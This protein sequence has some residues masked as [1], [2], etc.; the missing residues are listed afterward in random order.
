[1]KPVHVALDGSGL[2]VYNRATKAPLWWGMCGMI[3]IE[4]VVFASF[5]ASYLYLKGS[6]PEL[7]PPMRDG[8]PGLLLPTL[9]TFVLIASSL[10]MHWGDKGIRRGDNR[11]LR[12]GMVGALA[13]ALLFLVLKYVEYS[14]VPYRWDSHVYGSIVWTIIGFHTAHVIAV[15]LKGFIV[16][17]LAF[18]DY[19]DERR[20]LGV[21][22]NGLYWHFVVVIWIPLYITL[23]L[24]PR[25]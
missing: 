22:V 18:R 7:F 11:Q 16:A 6:S 1:M 9:N 15:V 8:P 20:H 23:Y 25:M 14:D 3:L 17:A 4:G 10:V 21:D 24:V 13:L 5:I 2:S 12:I 19:F